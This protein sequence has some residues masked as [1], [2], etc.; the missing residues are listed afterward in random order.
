MIKIEIDQNK[1]KK[2]EEMHWKWFKDNILKNWIAKMNRETD[3]EF[4]HLFFNN[5]SSFEEWFNKTKKESIQK[6]VNEQDDEKFDVF[7]VFLIGSLEDLMKIKKRLGVIR[8]TDDKIK[9][10]FENKYNDFRKSQKQ[11]GGALL[12]NELNI[13]VC[14]YCNRSF[15]DTYTYLQTGKIISNAQLDHFYCK[16]Q[17]PYLAVSL[18]NLIPC[19][20]TCNHRKSNNGENIIYPYKECFGENAKFSTNFITSSERVSYDINYLFGVTDNFEIN[21]KINEDEIK[22]ELKINSSINKKRIDL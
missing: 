5:R 13:K 11:W 17:Y 3:N 21:I 15:L 6:W 22:K 7:K 18:Y 16:E 9:K 12:I 1:M 19:C 10:Y 4:L 20:A 14:P 8:G 2:I